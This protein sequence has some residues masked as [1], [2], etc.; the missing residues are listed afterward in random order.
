MSSFF[1]LKKM[2]K[3]SKGLRESKIQKVNS[4]ERKLAQKGE[5]QWGRSPLK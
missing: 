2:Q 4:G 1:S 3:S 5:G